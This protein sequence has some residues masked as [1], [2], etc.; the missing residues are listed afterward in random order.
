MEDIRLIPHLFRHESGRIISA[1]TNYWGIQYLEDAEDITSDTFLKAMEHW[2]YHGIPENPAG[3]LHRVARNLAHTYYRRNRLF[4]DK[5]VRDLGMG[6]TQEVPEIVFDPQKIV[7]GQLQML[8]RICSTDLTPAHQIALSLRILCGFGIEE[9]ATALLASRDTIN[10]RLYRAK[11]KLR[12]SADF[13]MTISMDKGKS[14]D[15]VLRTLYL[16]YNE[17]YYS[18]SNDQILRKDLCREALYL[19][20]LLLEDPSTCRPDV[21]ALLALMSFHA[22]R[23]NTRIN[24]MGEMVLYE[25]QDPQQ[26]EEKLI[27]QGVYFLHQS[28]QGDHLTSYHLEANIAYH[29]TRKE[30]H[31]DKWKSILEL[32]DLLLKIN[33]S[34][35]IALNRIFAFS[36]VF[37]DL[38]AIEELG[39]IDVIPNQ[40]FFLLKGVLYREIDHD[41]AMVF[42][43]KAIAVTHSERERQFIRSQYLVD[44]AI[45]F[46]Y[47]H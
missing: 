1:L 40:Y 41:K 29:Y 18:E 43:L 3:W 20:H 34:P 32:Y 11:E 13:A 46:L 17:G 39:K 8:F 26:W 45:S 12:R 42:F 6:S 10:K 38:R 31:V 5:I 9:I 36:K 14:I 4:Q 19:T 28:A 44:E 7:D 21:Y 15:S 16:L 37:G 47:W 30:E 23:F 35:V 33:N 27:D 24:Q 25:K 22:S 2:P